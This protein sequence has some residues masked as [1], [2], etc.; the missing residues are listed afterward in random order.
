MVPCQQA[1]L[2]RVDKATRFTTKSVLCVVFNE[3]GG[4]P[5][6]TDDTR[7][8]VQ[9]MNK[10]GDGGSGA[11][12]VADATRVREEVSLPCERSTFH[13]QPTSAAASQQPR[14]LLLLVTVIGT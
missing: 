12:E 2:D 14:L 9:L 1:F 5:A 8:V 3:S 6:K 4:A 7:V 10:L 13:W 11:F